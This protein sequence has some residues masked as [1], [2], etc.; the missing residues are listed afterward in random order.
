MNKKSQR[1]KV[2]GAKPGRMEEESVTSG[3]EV[4]VQ[5]YKFRKEKTLQN[6]DVWMKAFQGGETTDELEKEMTK[7]Y[8]SVFKTDSWTKTLSE[9][10]INIVSLLWK[11][12]NLIEATQRMVDILE[13]G[14]QM[15]LGKTKDELEQWWQVVE[16]KQ[17]DERY[18]VPNTARTTKG[19]KNYYRTSQQQ[20]QGAKQR[21]SFTA[22]PELW[23]K[24]D[25]GTKREFVEFRKRAT[26]Q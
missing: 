13:A 9:K 2:K 16:A 6:P 19:T 24:W 3:D 21:Q 4:D 23:A 12:N 7:R 5:Q 26:K 1:K 22:P 18:K 15:A 10:I 14:R 20:N 17:E 25:P 8:V 11:E